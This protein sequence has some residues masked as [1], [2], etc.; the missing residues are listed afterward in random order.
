MENKINLQAK[1]KVL[2]K[3]FKA[4]FCDE[5]KI[6]SIKLGDTLRIPDCSVQDISIIIEF[7]NAIKTKKYLPFLVGYD[8][9]RK[10]E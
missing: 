7:Q 5:K 2:E 10:E 1:T 8:G 9:E 6:L 3:I 4:G